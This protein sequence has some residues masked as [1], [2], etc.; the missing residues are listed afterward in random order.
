MML[1][2]RKPRWV[3]KRTP[4][5]KGGGKEEVALLRLRSCP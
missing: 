5:G 2:A 3:E 1:A 4:E